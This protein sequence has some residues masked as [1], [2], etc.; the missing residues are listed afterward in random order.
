MKRMNFPRRKE[1]RRQAATKARFAR[2]GRTT[3][4]QIEKLDN[5]GHRAAK[6]RARL[7][8]KG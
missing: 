5:G 4:Q 2:A 7:A 6:E 8:R 3:A 1:A